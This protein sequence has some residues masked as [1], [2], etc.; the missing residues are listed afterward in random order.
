LTPFHFNAIIFPL[1]NFFS[2]I[3]KE[4]KRRITI[5]LIPHGKIKPKKLSVPLF[6]FGIA[7]V[8]WTSVTLWAGYLSGR[9]IDYLKTKTDN[10]IMQ[11]RLLFF[12]DQLEK[13]KDMFEKAQTTDDK[14]RSILALDSRKSII[15][16]GLGYDFGKGGPT[17]SQANAF[18][19]ILKGGANKI[20]P[21]LLSL[22]TTAIKER[23]DYMQ[24]S[25][26]EITSHIQSQR[27]LFMAIPRGRPAEGT[28]SSLYGFR[29]HPFFQTKDLHSGLDIA[30]QKGTP[31]RC[32][33]NGKVVFSGWQS[34]YG[35]IIVVNHGYGYRTAYA[36]LF[37]RLVKNGDYVK[38]GDQL[39]LMGSTGAATGSHVHYEVHYKGKTVNPISYLNDYYFTQYER[40][41]YDKKK[42]KKF[43]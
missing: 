29:Y 2:K 15:E 8:L 30:N 24:K 6:F 12:A 3:K 33:A 14:L 17:P 41:Y 19:M 20:S 10:K 25:Y 21:N 32:T 34:G 28:I 38:R 39:A 40:N 37:K 16:E 1:M 42:F 35:N 23:Y 7:L 26:V 9:H 43:A 36:H 5:M 4:L 27:S 13:T 22:K 31:V 18:A 11:L